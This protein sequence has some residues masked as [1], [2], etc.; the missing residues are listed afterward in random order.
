MDKPQ[1]NY[2]EWNKPDKREYIVYD[3]NYIKLQKCNLMHRDRKHISEY[4]AEGGV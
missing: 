1:N 3:A 2:T 4:L